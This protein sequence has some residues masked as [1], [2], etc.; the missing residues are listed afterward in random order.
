M[1]VPPPPPQASA[2]DSP[3]LLRPALA[4]GRRIAETPPRYLLGA[5]GPLLA[6]LIVMRVATGEN[7]PEQ[8][9]LCS[10]MMVLVV[11]SDASRRF[12]AGM[13]PL[14]LFGIVYDLTHLT[15]PLVRYLHVHVSEPYW[16]DKTFFGIP[17]PEG[18]LTPNEFFGRHHWAWVDFFTGFSY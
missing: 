2:A 13:L 12:F 14:L 6:Y 9:I 18:T 15:Q 5:I 7:R 16:F 4:L 17:S 10:L 3:M 8:L 1:P 11:W